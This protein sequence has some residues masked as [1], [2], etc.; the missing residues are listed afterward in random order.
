MKKD[1]FICEGG[2]MD[3]RVSILQKL[4]PAKHTAAPYRGRTQENSRKLGEL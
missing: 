1:I 2:T 3:Y 4:T